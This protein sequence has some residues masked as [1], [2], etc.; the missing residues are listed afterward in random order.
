M[1]YFFLELFLL[2]FI[3]LNRG[4]SLLSHVNISCG[5]KL[6]R[7]FRIVVLKR[8]IFLLTLLFEKGLIQLNL[9]IAHRILTLV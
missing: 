5:M 4:R 6:H 8:L 3:E 2:L 1:H 7:I 9:L